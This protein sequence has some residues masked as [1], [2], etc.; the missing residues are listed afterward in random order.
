MKNYLKKKR[1]Y[2]FLICLISFLILAILILKNG[3]LDID[4]K[5][6][7]FIKNTFISEKF[8]P[9]IKILTNLGGPVVLLIVSIIIM[10]FIKNKRINIAIIVNL[11]SV[12]LLNQ[13]LKIIIQRSRPNSINW[14][15]IESGYS[16]PSGH[17]MV[18]MG[19]YG[20]LIYLVY[21][22]IN[23]K[24]KWIIISL[25]SLIILFIGISRIY[26]GVHFLSDILGGFLGAIMYLIVFVFCYN[27]YINSTKS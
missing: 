6:Y 3:V 11:I 12:F 23:K 9:Y 17:A 25:I 14:L 5:F 19:Y 21:T 10:F 16:F 15:V 26:L 7:D 2:I 27:K 24:Y 4:T 1:F 22:R 20:F 18:S 13:L 8:T